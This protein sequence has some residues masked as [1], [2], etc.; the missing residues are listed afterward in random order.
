MK[1]KIKNE[2]NLKKKRQKKKEGTHTPCI[3]LKMGIQL[4]EFSALYHLRAV[5]CGRPLSKHIGGTV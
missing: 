2:W 1:K 5:P 3:V 4:E